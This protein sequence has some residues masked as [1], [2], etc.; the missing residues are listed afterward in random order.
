M[1]D[2]TAVPTIP[3]RESDAHKGAFG[4]VLVV[5][6]AVGFTGAP[7]MACEGALRT[8][9]GLVTC[10]CPAHLLT[11]IA[12]KLTEAMTFPLPTDGQGCLSAEAARIL[13]VSIDR[14][15][16][17]VVGP[18]LGAH[19]TTREFVRALLAGVRIPSVVDADGLRAF[20]SDHAVPAHCVVT[21]H[22]GEFARMTGTAAAAVQAARRD[23]ALGFAQHHEGTLVLKGGS[24]I[25]CDKERCYVNANGNPGMATGGAGDVL[26]GVIGALLGQDFEP[27]DAAVLGVWLHGRAGDLACEELGEESMLARDIARHLSR[28]TRER[29]TGVGDDA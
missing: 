26:A 28:A 5:G 23:H 17:L 11:I 22:P 20:D 6:G 27:F 21:P 16:A 3:L 9:A 18:G 24:T 2:V 25:V 4:H 19:D 14:F 10:A 13:L 15:D 7:V 1:I 29:K 12:T 8:G